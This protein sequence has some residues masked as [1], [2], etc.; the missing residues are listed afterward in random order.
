[1]KIVVFL[2]FLGLYLAL[3]AAVPL[4]NDN[5]S[6]RSDQLVRLE[7]VDNAAGDAENVGDRNARHWGGGWG[8][9]Y[10]GW[11]GYGGGWRRHGWGGYGGWGGGGYGGGWGRGYGGW[12]GY[13]GGYW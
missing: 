10:G 6:E 1:M 9:G 12:G 8:G 13:G 5:N 11:G 4:G 7:D 2:L 3:A